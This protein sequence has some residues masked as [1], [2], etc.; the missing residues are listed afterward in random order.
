VFRFI[1]DGFGT[2]HGAVHFDLRER[3]D[4]YAGLRPIYLFHDSDTP[5]K[6]PAAGEIDFIL[7]RESTE[8]LF[9]ARHGTYSATDSMA[10]DSIR[11]QARKMLAVMTINS[12]LPSGACRSAKRP[13]TA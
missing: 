11:A 12:G 1:E 10:C 7:V 8:G 13:I 3:L 2:G 9:S 5:L 4:L 6:G